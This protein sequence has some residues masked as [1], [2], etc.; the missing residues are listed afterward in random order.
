ME[1][2]INSMF[3]NTSHGLVQRVEILARTESEV[4]RTENSEVG[5]AVPS[6]LYGWENHPEFTRSPPPR[7]V[8]LEP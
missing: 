8:G 5:F 4:H 2:F 7:I 6:W 3:L 1:G